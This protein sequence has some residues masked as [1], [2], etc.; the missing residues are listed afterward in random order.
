MKLSKE[1]LTKDQWRHYKTFGFLPGE[2]PVGDAIQ[3]TV[4]S[5]QEK[6]TVLCVRFGNKYG[7]DYVER[8]RNMVARHIT[9]PYEFACLTDDP[10]RIEG[11]RTIYQRSSGYNKPW[12]HKVH[13]FDGQLDI[14]GRIIYFDLDVV[15]SGS[16]DKLVVNLKDEFYGIQDFNRKFHPTWRVLNSSIM[17]WRHGTQNTIWEK[18]IANPSQ[19]QRLHGDQDWIWAVAKDRIKFWPQEWIQSYKWE[20]RSREE[21][22]SRTGR[23]GFKTVAQNLKVHPELAVAVFHGD[24]KPE[25]VQD[26]FVVDNWR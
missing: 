13:M 19:A 15:I 17:T 3:P 14:S 2:Q 23:L 21:L 26:Q 16:I 12:W 11:V 4:I 25:D 8:L 24:P 5:N 1:N 20:I 7:P 9:V 10:N 18:F 6:I 22:H